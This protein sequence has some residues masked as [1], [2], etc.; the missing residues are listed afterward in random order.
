MFSRLELLLARQG[1]IL[2]LS[3]PEV[4]LFTRA[5]ERGAVLVPRAS[6][7]VLHSLGRAFELTVPA[8]AGGR[9]R[10]APPEALLAPVGYG[11]VL[12]EL[13]PLG[14]DLGAAPAPSEAGGVAEGHLAFRAPC[15][16]RFWLRPS[17]QDPPFVSAGDVVEDGRTLGLI[18]VMKTFTHVVYRS[19]A[20]LPARARIAR[21]CVADGSEVEDG[22]ALVEL[23][24]A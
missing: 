3:S 9:V 5:A 21:L 16:G 10:N 13:E 2:R 14:A 12:Y 22:T 19:G 6:C 20:D 18:E 8:G 4:G 1:E 23:E 17:P 24:S 11:T 7:G 15:S